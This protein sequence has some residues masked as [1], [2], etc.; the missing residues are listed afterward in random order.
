[1]DPLTHCLL[2]GVAAKSVGTTK[3]RFWIMMFLGEAPDLDV[4]FN[5]LGGWAFWLQHRGISH[6]LI[7]V[8]LQAFFYAWVFNKMDPGIYSRRVFHYSLPLAF[9]LICDGLT[10]YGVPLFSPFSFRDYSAN[11][12]AGMTIIPMV[13]MA[14]G[15]LWIIRKEK[16]GWFATGP[17]WMGWVLCLLLAY[18]GKS[19]ASKYIERSPGQ[20][21]AL[22]AT[23][24]PFSWSIVRV[25]K[26]QLTY[27]HYA[28]D[29]LKGE[30]RK[31]F[32]LNSGRYDFPVQASM[33]SADVQAFMRENR[34]PVVRTQ[35]VD[36][37]WVV[38]WGNLLFSSRGMVRGKVRVY[39]SEMGD[40][41]K[42]EKIFGFW[43][44]DVLPQLPS[45][46]VSTTAQ[47]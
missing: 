10:S 44:P 45:P 25:D 35:K 32:E 11:L 15:L 4:L 46:S 31:V 13:I 41:E 38:E 34:W 30:R 26:E 2:G 28:I 14:V 39:V 24:N 40:I 22:P 20:V 19:Y 12:M 3:R 21:T 23:I 47:S 43:N 7:G 33:A 9:H 37:T 1:M 5:Y 18:T 29:L 8:C 42:E 16:S 27:Q 17:I 36:N 6:S